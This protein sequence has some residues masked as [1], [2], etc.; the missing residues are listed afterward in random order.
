EI[1]I[2]VRVENYGSATL[3]GGVFTISDGI[4]GVNSFVWSG[5]L[6]PGNQEIIT[7]G[8]YSI[9][10]NTNFTFTF[11]GDDFVTNNYFSATVERGII[12]EYGVNGPYKICSGEVIGLNAWGGESYRWLNATADS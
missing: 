8:D 11:S 1:P 5:I 7:L 3:N 2:S 6:L 4:S 12:T 9:D 10:S